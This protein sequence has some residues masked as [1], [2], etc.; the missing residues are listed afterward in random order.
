MHYLDGETAIRRIA[1]RREHFVPMHTK[2][3]VEYLAQHCDTMQEQ[4]EFRRL[5]SLILSLLHQM[6]RL[7]HE[8]LTYTYA[9]LDPDRDKMLVCVPTVGRGDALCQ[10][11]FE[12]T[13]DVLKRA[14]YRRLSPHEIQI[15]LR[16]ASQWGVRMRVNFAGMR[17]LEVY[18][19]GGVVGSR[20]IRP[21][22]KF[23]KLQTV[24]V[25][26]YQRLVVVF[27]TQAGSIPSEFDP[28]RVYL[29]MF[30]NVPQEDIDMMLPAIGIRMSWLDHSKIVVPSLYAASMTLWRVL[31]NVLLLA[32]FG[33]FKTVAM[34]VL[35]LFAIGFGFKSMFTYRTNTKRRYMLNMAQS[36]YYQ[37]LDNNAGVLLRLL[38]EG[39]QQE[40]CE[41]VLG[42]YV[43]AI[44]CANAGPQD[45]DALDAAC[46][47]MLRE[48]TGLDV[49][50]DADATFRT[51]IQLGV[52]TI[53]EG[54][55]TALPLKEAILKLDQLWDN[56]FVCKNDQAN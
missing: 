20:A 11:L 37:N 24:E 10:E 38:D 9:L 33:V 47:D 53:D 29:R 46:E 3:M 16:A 52:V 48:A 19:R 36:L 42:Y 17:K 5:A 26:L 12:K 44:R 45:L 30:K 27:R 25:P 50:Y 4:Q 55:W 28:R 49:D 56:W 23:F 6:Y 8:Q 39:E 43:L 32:L 35:V 1:G 21:W 14:N 40:A 13:Q 54:G 18:A 22:Y 41:A 34:V 7:R 31:R 51:L 15:A 2:D